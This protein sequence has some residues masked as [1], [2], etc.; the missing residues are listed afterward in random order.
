MS[1]R[2]SEP[3]EVELTAEVKRTERLVA[4]ENSGGENSS[5]GLL[6]SVV[7]LKITLIRTDYVS[8]AHS[9]FPFHSS[10]TV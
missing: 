10:I 8:V 3:P 4:I 5:K 1:Q 9:L 6:L 7:F 2:D